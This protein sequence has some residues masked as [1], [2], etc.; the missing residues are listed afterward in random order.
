MCFFAAHLEAGALHSI[1]RA[2]VSEVLTLLKVLL[3][4]MKSDARPKRG[5]CRATPWVAFAGSRLLHSVPSHPLSFLG[6]WGLVTVSILP[7]K[8]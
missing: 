7:T 2:V 6:F 1:K 8:T 4:E 3:D 5:L